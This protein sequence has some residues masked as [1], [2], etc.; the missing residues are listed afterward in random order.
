MLSPQREFKSP[1]Q[2]VHKFLD[3]T[4]ALKKVLPNELF[5]IN[6]ATISIID[7]IICQKPE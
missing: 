4:F 6:D 3:E 2:A 5:V 7:S 1:A